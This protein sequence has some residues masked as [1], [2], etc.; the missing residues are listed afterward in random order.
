ML[1]QLEKWETTLR[2]FAHS[3]SCEDISSCPLEHK[4]CR[5]DLNLAT[6]LAWEVANQLGRISS[7]YNSLAWELTHPKEDQAD[8][9]PADR[10][11]NLTRDVYIIVD[12]LKSVA[13]RLGWDY[14]DLYYS[15]VD[16]EEFLYWFLKSIP[17]IAVEMELKAL[18]SKTPKP[19]EEFRRALLCKLV[20]NLKKIDF[21]ALDL[22]YV[23][24]VYSTVDTLTTTLT[25]S[26]EETEFF[27]NVKDVLK[28][29]I[30]IS[31]QDK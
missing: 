8:D 14:K 5:K 30:S 6:S 4:E 24:Q 1:D 26:E 25:D 28:R 17:L 9:Q 2:K 7:L 19:I 20:E 15:I 13:G 29:L 31:E 11:F 21:E 27:V 12:S 16:V 22:P 18:I 10:L 23:R 3:G